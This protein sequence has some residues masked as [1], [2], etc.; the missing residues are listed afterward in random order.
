MAVPC[1]GHDKYNAVPWCRLMMPPCSPMVHTTACHDMLWVIYHGSF[2]AYHT[3]MGRGPFTVGPW[4]VMIG[5]WIAYRW[6]MDLSWTAH[7]TFHGSCKNQGSRKA[8]KKAAVAIPYHCHE[9][10]M[11]LSWQIPWD[12]QWMHHGPAMV[13]MLW[14]DRGILKARS[15]DAP[16]DVT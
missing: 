3:W 2:M 6:F 15:W 1:Q 11:A 4:M 16:C 10:A 14:N 5:P 8:D 13:V 9:N 12:M 7:G